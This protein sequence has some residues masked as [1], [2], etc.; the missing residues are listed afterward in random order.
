ME[1]G[2]LYCVIGLFDVCMKKFGVWFIF[3]D[4]VMNNVIFFFFI[5]NVSVLLSLSLNF[6]CKI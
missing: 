4:N 6:F 3:C 5:L 2:V 1:M